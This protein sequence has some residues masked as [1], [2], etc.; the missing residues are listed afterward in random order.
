MDREQRSNWIFEVLSHILKA[1]GGNSRIRESLIF[2]GA[3]VLNQHLGTPRMSLDIDSNLDA[4]FTRQHPDKIVQKTFLEESIS[5]ALTRY[6]EDQDPVRFKVSH[7]RVEPNPIKGHPL[8]WDAF[9]IRI[10][11]IDYEKL[12]VRDLP[13]LRVDVAAPE[14][15][16]DDSVVVLPL[17]DVTVKAYSL[18]R[19]AGEKARAFLSSLPAY[20]EKL[21]KRPKAIRVKDLYDLTRIIQARPINDKIFWK[22]AGEEFFLASESRYVDCEGLKTFR[23]NWEVTSRLF[24]EDPIIPTDISIADVEN[25]LVA[26]TDYWESI[27]LLPFSFPL[28]G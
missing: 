8:G 23:E 6:F 15:L 17:G 9:L 24:S 7:I 22:K 10:S 27:N 2:K 28:P 26:I 3:M 16:S 21:D 12:G 20:R 11:L 5:E 4:E 18:E 13:G 1:L 25:T 14:T 19:I